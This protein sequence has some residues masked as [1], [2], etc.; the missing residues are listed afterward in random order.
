MLTALFSELGLDTGFSI[1]RVQKVLAANAGSLEYLRDM[2][3]A[4]H[5]SRKKGV[6]KSPEIIK[7]PSYGGT[8]ILPL[9]RDY[10]WNIKHVFVTTRPLEPFIR[11]HVHRKRVGKYEELTQRQLDFLTSLYYFN[12]RRIYGDIEYHQYPYTV[13]DFPLLVRSWKYT[14]R[15][16]KPLL[17]EKNISKDTFL[18]SWKRMADPKLVHF[19]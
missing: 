18:A 9:A 16:F 7:H 19:T 2:R 14:Y 5:K 6:D 10:G 1:K 3:V 4:F 8:F 17:L 12:M 15:K 11:S 13:L